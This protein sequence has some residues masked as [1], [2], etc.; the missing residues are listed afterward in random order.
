MC[1]CSCRIYTR[2]IDNFLYWYVTA[3]HTGTNKS[4][5][6]QIYKLVIPS[7]FILASV[8]CS[9]MHPLKQLRAAY[10]WYELRGFFYMYTIKKDIVFYYGTRKKHDIFLFVFHKMGSIIT[11]P[12]TWLSYS[13]V[14]SI[15]WWC[16]FWQHRF[17]IESRQR[18][19]HFCIPEDQVPFDTFDVQFICFFGTY[20]NIQPRQIGNIQESLT[21]IEVRMLPL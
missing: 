8:V 2:H 5:W 21:L 17:C 3:K 12:N 14:H 19:Q 7:K 18:W 20:N 1:T 11:Y 16:Q 4:I 13:R 15:S 9:C 6:P 10:S